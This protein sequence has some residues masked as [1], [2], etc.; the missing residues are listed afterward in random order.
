MFGRFHKS[1]RL[2]IGA[3]V[4]AMQSFGLAAQDD[5][6]SLGIPRTES[7]DEQH[8][9]LLNDFETL[10]ENRTAPDESEYRLWVRAVAAP[11]TTALSTCAY[12]MWDARPDRGWREARFD[13]NR[14]PQWQLVSVGGSPP[15]DEELS[16]FNARSK[17]PIE[18]AR[19][20]EE[21]ETIPTEALAVLHRKD[22]LVFFGAKP[23]TLDGAPRS[24][25]KMQPLFMIVVSRD[26]ARVRIVD[27]RATK[28]FSPK[29]GIR[30]S[31]MHSRVIYE[32][33]SDVDAMVTKYGEV[34]TRGR[35]F[36]IA[37][38]VLDESRWYDD[39]S[40]PSAASS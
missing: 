7:G 14:E 32:Y 6:R 10:W 28:P 16:E 39:I 38:F 26:D 3:C 13:P 33:N 17:P 11:E 19:F 36:A 30:V 29:L 8:L 9:Q 23:H 21:G 4:L 15:S 37:K 24:A 1:S 31:S 22:D 35:A 20:M 27:V 5:G 12:T 34:K 18:T 25:R 40:C 2:V